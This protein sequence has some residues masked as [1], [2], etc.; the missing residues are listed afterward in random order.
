M[1][2][3]TTPT[4]TFTLPF[5]A[6][7]I[8]KARVLYSQNDA[9]ILRKEGSDITIDGNTLVVRLSQED[10]FKFTLGFQKYVEIQVRV[11][12][13]ANESIVSDIIRVPVDRCLEEDVLV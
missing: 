6:T 7:M 8:A 2:R 10:T 11:L 5:D 4:H 3:G 13:P 9:V 1:K 12:T